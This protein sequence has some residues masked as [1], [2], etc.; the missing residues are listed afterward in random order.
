MT[1]TESP[2]DSNWEPTRQVLHL[3]ICWSLYGHT[4]SFVLLSG[5]KVSNPAV[6]RGEL[7]VGSQLIKI[8]L[9]SSS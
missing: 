9:I 1:K 5:I 6:F 4:P 8:G 2:L 7:T 3:H